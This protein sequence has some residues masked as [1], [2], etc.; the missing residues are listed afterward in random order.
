MDGKLRDIF[1]DI[2]AFILGNYENIQGRSCYCCCWKRRRIVIQKMQRSGN[3][4]IFA[5]LFLQITSS[6]DRK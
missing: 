6:Y 2:V 4:P 3:I 1:V 5:T